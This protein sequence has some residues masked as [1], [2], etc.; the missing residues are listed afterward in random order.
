MRLALELT[1]LDAH[2]RER[3][4]RHEPGQKDPVEASAPVR[5]PP[6]PA[7][8]VCS[9]HSKN[10]AFFSMKLVHSGGTSVSGKMA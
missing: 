10:V 3:P 5:P 1:S 2:E 7:R 8:T 9:H 4:N 6:V